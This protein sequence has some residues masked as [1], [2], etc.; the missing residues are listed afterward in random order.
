MTDPRLQRLTRM[1]AMV[2]DARSAEVQRTR[3]QRD[4][5]L[6]Q[7]AALERPAAEPADLAQARAALAYE[8]WAAQRRAEIDA[9]LALH[10]RRLKAQMAEARRAFG[11]RQ[12]LD[13][14]G[15]D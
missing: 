6:E 1:A 15:K 14:M 5:L 10:D 8:G 13:R 2:L 7:R 9:R 11:R 3:A 4:A 12:V